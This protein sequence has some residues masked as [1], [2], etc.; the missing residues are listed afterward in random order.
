MPVIVLAQVRLF[1]CGLGT[2]VRAP[3]FVVD[4][5]QEHG[6][7]LFSLALEDQLS[8]SVPQDWHVCSNCA[9]DKNTPKACDSKN[10]SSTYQKGN[11]HWDPITPFAFV[12]LFFSLDDGLSLGCILLDR[13]GFPVTSPCLFMFV[14]LK[15]VCFFFFFSPPRECQWGK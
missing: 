13:R 7:C 12:D 9:W 14:K 11:Q 3:L 6:R 10:L 2:L 4:S 1:G 15:V 5:R 8:L